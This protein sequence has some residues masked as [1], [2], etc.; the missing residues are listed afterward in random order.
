MKL[1]WHR[2]LAIVALIAVASVGVSGTANKPA[3]KPKTLPRL[4]DLGAE[5]CIPCKM[6][7]PILGQLAREY[8]GQLK[9]EFVDVYKQPK[10]SAKYKIKSYPTQIFFDA[11]GKERF[12]HEGFYSKAAILRKFKQLGIKLTK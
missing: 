5:K 1:K 3:P 7:K 10:E 2:I 4:V 9:V 8:K 6:M 12:R 11:T